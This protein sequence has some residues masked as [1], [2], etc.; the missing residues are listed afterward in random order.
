[1]NNTRDKKHIKE[2]GE[3]FRRI[4]KSLNRTQKDLAFDANIEVSQISRLEN[5]INNPTLSTILLLA[6]VMEIPASR[7]FEYSTET[8]AAAKKKQKK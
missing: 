4:R 2:F 1:M 8:I 3:N 6:E 5:G 7:L